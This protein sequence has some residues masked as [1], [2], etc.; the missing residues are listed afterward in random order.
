MWIF[1]TRGF[2][3]I[4]QAPV[5][6]RMLVRARFEGDIE[7]LLPGAEVS[8]TPE[9]DYMYRTIVTPE[10]VIAA[11][12][13]VTLDID[14]PNFKDA[15]LDDKRHPAYGNVWGIMYNAGDNRPR[16]ESWYSRMANDEPAI[17]SRRPAQ[18]KKRKK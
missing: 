2:Y 3:S 6:G 11:L 15:V 14:Y 9:R 1:T 10:D 16:I 18:K 12:S 4:V 17:V 8:V 5:P 7:A 13:K